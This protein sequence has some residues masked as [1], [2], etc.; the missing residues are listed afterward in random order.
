ML[1]A[2]FLLLVASPF[3]HGVGGVAVAEATSA[4]EAA[5]QTL[6]VWSTSAMEK[7]AAPQHQHGRGSAASA[8]S[9]NAAGGLGSSG[10]RSAVARRLL[11]GGAGHSCGSSG[12]Q[13]C[14][15]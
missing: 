5:K 10:S 8:M 12:G 11:P 6:M 2:C 1:M 4:E 3:L 15:P 13:G 7:T 14:S 9:S